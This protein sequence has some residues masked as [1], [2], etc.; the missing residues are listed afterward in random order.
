MTFYETPI[1]IYGNIMTTNSKEYWAKYRKR[2]PEKVKEYRR[3]YR[4]K[5]RDELNAKHREYSKRTN[6]ASQIT[7]QKE[8]REHLLEYYKKRTEKTRKFYFEYKKNLICSKCGF[9]DWRI[10][11]FHHVKGKKDFTVSQGMIHSIDTIKK[12]IEK[13]V[14]LCPNCHKLEHLGDLAVESRGYWAKK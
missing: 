14:P 8:N 11:E 5:H 7:W 3:R 2:Y 12:E 13:C 10:L 6:Y 1:N 9:D 4:V